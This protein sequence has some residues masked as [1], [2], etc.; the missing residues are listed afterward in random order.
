MRCRANANQWIPNPKDLVPSLSCWP[1]LVAV[2]SCY[3][4]S[5]MPSHVAL[6]SKKTKLS[7]QGKLPSTQS[8]R[9]HHYLK[10]EV[11]TPVNWRKGGIDRTS[12]D[13]IRATIRS[14]GALAA[15]QP[16]PGVPPASRC[17]S[18]AIFCSGVKEGVPFNQASLVAYLSAC[19]C[20]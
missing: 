2:C 8:M 6:E 3:S 12:R 5:R 4:V 9:G 14:P 19:C 10:L 18:L 17:G 7:K 13:P 20:W 15:W 11:Q 1:Q 16:T